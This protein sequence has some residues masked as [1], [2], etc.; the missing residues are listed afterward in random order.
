[1][2]VAV[3]RVGAPS[4]QVDSFVKEFRLKPSKVFH[5]GET[6]VKGPASRLSGFNLALADTESLA[7]LQA[8]ISTFLDQYKKPIRALSK[9]QI[10][11]TLDIGMTVGGECHYT[12]SISFSPSLLGELASLNMHLE[13]SAY[14][15]EED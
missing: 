10:E 12:S 15:S 6:S 1:M 5:E 11:S 8:Q 4:F 7:E 2:F 9:L 13:V 14:P 3:W